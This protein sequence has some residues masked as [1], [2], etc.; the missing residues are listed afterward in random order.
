VSIQPPG[1]RAADVGAGGSDRYYTG[2]R[3]DLRALV[4]ATARRVL[5]VGCGA[6]S[7]GAALR[8]E[9]AAEVVGIEL[10]AEAAELAEARLDQVLRL[11]LQT[12]T[13]LP[14][15]D[16]YFDAM[17]F[18]DVL[19][20]MHDPHRLLRTLRRYLTDDGWIVCSIPNVKHWTVVFQLLVRDRWEYADDGLLDR[21]HV[22]L[23]T[24]EEIGLMLDET[25]F[26]AV[27][28]Q[29]ITTDEIPDQI[30]SLADFA[31]L[32]GEARDEVLQRLNTYQ[33]LVAAQPA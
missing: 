32:F 6:G 3:P 29:A 8:A 15:P 30:R 27:H 33:Y 26:Q 1:V 23:F 28:L 13:E 25:G 16:G 14:Y 22:H 4:P 9:T 11:D 7:L 12:L 18:G 19:E 20:H 31:A 17:T 10:F 21:T 24:L 2:D 5:D